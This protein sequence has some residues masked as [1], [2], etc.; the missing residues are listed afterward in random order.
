MDSAEILKG[1]R[2]TNERCLILEDGPTAVIGDLHLGYESALEDEGLYIPRMN[3]QSIRDSLNRILWRYEPKR[4]VL[5][6]DIKHDFR[7]AVYECRDEVSTIL[8]MLRDA[9]EV[10][11]VKGNHDNFIQN[12][13]SGMGMTAW[14]SVDIAG[15]RMEHGHEDSGK[16]PVIIAHEHPSV[17]FPGPAGA[18]VKLQCFVH[19]KEEGII[20]IPPFS[21]FSSGNDIAGTEFMSPACRSA[22]TGNAD[23]YGISELGVLR[24]GKLKG[25]SEIGL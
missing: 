22:D 3:T 16:R 23:I 4:F 14:N 11:V 8:E 5:L 15:F 13:L 19:M 18:G 24:M 7:R 20:V 21:P 9:A 10:V 12:I 17:R 2:V 25:L 1:V 6:G